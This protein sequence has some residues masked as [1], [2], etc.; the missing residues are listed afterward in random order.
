M[1]CTINMIE[2]WFQYSY[3]PM[4]LGFSYHMK[5]QYLPVL[6]FFSKGGAI[7]KDGAVIRSFMVNILYT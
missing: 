7:I 1:K 3:T 6:V 4:S 2:C 5:W